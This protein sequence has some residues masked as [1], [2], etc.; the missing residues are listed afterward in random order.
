MKYLMLVTVLTFGLSAQAE[1]FYSE[2][3]A[4]KGTIAG[5]TSRVHESYNNIAILVKSFWS[6]R[7]KNCS[8]APSVEAAFGYPDDLSFDLLNKDKLERE[9]GSSIWYGAPMRWKNSRLVIPALDYLG[10]GESPLT[11]DLV[12]RN[13]DF[14]HLEG[15]WSHDGSVADTG[16]GYGYNIKCVAKASKQQDLQILNATK[17]C[18]QY[19]AKH[20]L[21]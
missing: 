4:C 19:P 8:L 7:K 3:L 1:F 20:Y 11:L 12:D 6:V 21:D 2:Y 13:G 16:N 5:D 18:E 17:K 14:L 15:Y 9:T 10:Y